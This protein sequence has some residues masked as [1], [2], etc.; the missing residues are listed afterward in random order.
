MPALEVRDPIHG[1]IDVSVGERSVIDHRLF[2]RLRNVRQLGFSELAFPSATHNRYGHSIGA[3]WLAER[4]FRSIFPT[5]GAQRP[6]SSAAHERFRRC[7]R[8]ATLLHDVGHPP[9][10]HC[11]ES[12]MPPVE[13]LGLA[14]VRPARSGRRATHED[15][16]VKIIAESSLSPVIAQASEPAPIHVAALIDPDVPVDDDF[17]HDGGLDYRPLLSQLVSSE[18]DMDRVDYLLRDSHFAGVEYG[19]FDHRWLLAHLRAHVADGDRVHLALDQR[20]I[21]AFDDFLLSRYHMFL[22][23]YYHYRPVVFEEMMLRWFDEVG[24]HAVPTDVE[25]YAGADDPWLM[26]RLRESVSEWALRIVERRP[27]KLLLERHGSPAEDL[28]ELAERLDEAG[29]PYIA[30]D[31]WGILSK[32]SAAATTPSRAPTL[33][34]VDSSRLLPRPVRPI[35]ESTDLF[36]RYAERRQISRLYVPPE[37]LDEA[38]GLFGGSPAA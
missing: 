20:A 9:L 38:S 30:T 5:S 26:G 32:Y 17:F 34:V 24:G 7:L 23:V 19:R 31:S 37:Q 11:T 28:P 21:Y 6:L 33:Y 36:A 3:M 12:A 25:S 29:I 14:S 8:L 16:T 27:Y 18:L 13:D 22:M 10:S 1:A 2:Q 35:Q 15:F 4:A